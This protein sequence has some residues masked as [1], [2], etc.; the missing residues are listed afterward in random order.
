MDY[1][2]LVS[3]TLATPKEKRRGGEVEKLFP[4]FEF[5]V[6]DFPESYTTYSPPPRRLPSQPPDKRSPGLRC[7]P[8]ATIVS[9]PDFGSSRLLVRT[10]VTPVTSV[11]IVPICGVGWLSCS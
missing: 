5:P 6:G 2:K 4:E 10:A 1:R 3:L 8:Q 11:I 7:M 9:T